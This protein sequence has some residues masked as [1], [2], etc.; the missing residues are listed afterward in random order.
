MSVDPFGKAA[1]DEALRA[2]Q[3]DSTSFGHVELIPYKGHHLVPVV[4]LML[5]F[6]DH[7][8]SWRKSI[9]RSIELS[10]NPLAK[11]ERISEHSSPT[12]PSPERAPPHRG[13][14]SAY[15]TPLPPWSKEKDRS[16]TRLSNA[17]SASASAKSTACAP[18]HTLATVKLY[19]SSYRSAQRAI[20]PEH[21]ALRARKH[22]FSY[23][24]L[25][26][27]ETRA[28]NAAYRTQ[29]HKDQSNLFPLDAKEFI[30]TAKELLASERFISLGMG[31][32]AVTGRRPAEI[33]FSASF[34]P[35][36]QKLPF[37]AVIFS[38]Q[39]KTRNAPG[40]SFEPYPIPTLVPPKTVLEAFGRL[41]AIR[42]I[43]TS[44]APISLPRT[45]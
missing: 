19:L 13:L 43:P 2:H 44:N 41:R 38:G 20:D 30:A 42:P 37:P 26:P 39:L 6:P 36:A 8:P 15:P 16:A 22:R 21:P 23:L 12:S 34:A 33:F 40:T 29:I 25:T 45:P 18:S 14:L 17:C 9:A 5:L 3:L 27:E 35:L 32:M 28:I 10:R 31:L 4:W 7:Q 24:A 1:L 11:R